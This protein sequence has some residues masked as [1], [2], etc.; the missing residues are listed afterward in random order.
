MTRED[1]R[2]KCIKA[3][4][5]AIVTTHARATIAFDSL[6]TAN[7]SVCPT[8]ATEEMIRASARYYGDPLTAYETI[9]AAGNL[10]NPPEKKP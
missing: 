1:Y 8:K 10:L 3:I 5:Q 4:M 2:E 6:A 9:A 7:V